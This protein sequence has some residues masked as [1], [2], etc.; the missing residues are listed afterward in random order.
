MFKKTNNKPGCIYHNDCI[1][2]H[3]AVKTNVLI[4]HVKDQ[5]II[6]KPTNA[7]MTGTVYDLKWTCV[8]WVSAY[9][10][11]LN[12]NLS[13][14]ELPIHK[15]NLLPSV[16]REGVLSQLISPRGTTTPFLKTKLSEGSQSLKLS[17]IKNTKH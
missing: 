14:R 16:V 2:A 4:N 6:Y 13:F 17:L 5:A 11:V 3:I 12:Y 8:A 1:A 15:Q 7:I 9:T 10:D